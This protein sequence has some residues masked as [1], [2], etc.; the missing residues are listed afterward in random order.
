MKKEEIIFYDKLKNI[1][2]NEYIVEFRK[3]IQDSALKDDLIAQSNLFETYLTNSINFYRYYLLR[4]ICD[5]SF[6]GIKYTY[7]I[8]QLLIINS[9]F[10]FHKESELEAKIYSLLYDELRGNFNNETIESEFFKKF[11]KGLIS[12]K[13]DTT[14]TAYYDMPSP[15]QSF[16]TLLYYLINAS[17]A[18][19]NDFTLRAD[20]KNMISPM[21]LLNTISFH[22]LIENF[23]TNLHSLE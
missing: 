11:I 9:H 2:A 18:E 14:I 20:Y 12:K 5:S 19:L 3:L 1:S 13:N 17:R 22:H 6:D 4:D 10:N 7:T 16:T 23:G 15:S 21:S 8:P